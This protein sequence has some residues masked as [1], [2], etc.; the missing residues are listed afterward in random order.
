MKDILKKDWIYLLLILLMAGFTYCGF[1]L[2][3]HGFCTA[4]DQGYFLLKAEEALDGILTGKSQWNFF[5]V[6]WFP[7]LDLTNKVHSHIASWIL[8]FASSVFATITLCVIKKDKKRFIKYF[9]LVYTVLFIAYHTVACNILTGLNYVPIHGFLLNISLCLFLLYWYVHTRWVSYLCFALSVTFAMLGCFVI[10]PGASLVLV[11]YALISILKY[12]RNGKTLIIHIALGVGGVV[13]ALL[14]I[15]YVIYDLSDIINAMQETAQYFTKT[16]LGYTPTKIIIAFGRLIRSLLVCMLCYVGAYA[17]SELLH[18]KNNYLSMLIYALCLI[19]IAHYVPDYMTVALVCSTIFVIP[20]LYNGWSNIKKLIKDNGLLYTFLIAYPVIASVGTNTGFDGRIHMFVMSWIIYWL[21]TERFASILQRNK[22]E[23][24]II[25]VA[26]FY[27]TKVV[28]IDFV[29]RDDRHHFT[30]GRE[31][32][33]EI[34]LTEQQVRYLNDIQHIVSQ[35]GYKPNESVVFATGPEYGV[36][37]ALE[38]ILSSN[39][40]QSKQFHFFDKSKM[41]KPDFMMMNEWESPFIDEDLSMQPWGW[42]NE[43][44]MYIVNSPSPKEDDC[45]LY[46]RKS[47]KILE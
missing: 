47:K 16:G 6:D 20:A 42:P 12:Y 3:R 26:L 30:T 28:G 7:Y 11:S 22:I 36:V 40:H 18:I 46:C 35:Y 29:M 44:D 4:Y 23:I 8:M 45:I 9:A 41:L 10:L 5:A 19:L 21:I 2:F 32:I 25:A 14:Y 15:H 37:Y 34:A 27:L 24:G 39:F 38:G 1:V 33:K 43:F 13:I 17:V 31:Q